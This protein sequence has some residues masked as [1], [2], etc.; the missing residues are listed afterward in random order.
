[1]VRNGAKRDDLVNGAVRTCLS[2]FCSVIYGTQCANLAWSCLTVSFVKLL[3]TGEHCPCCSVLTYF[4]AFQQISYVILHG[5]SVTYVY[6][7]QMVRKLQKNYRTPTGFFSW[8]MV[9]P[10]NFFYWFFGSAF[11]FIRKGT[12][13]IL[14]FLMPTRDL[15]YML[16]RTRL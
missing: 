9:L 6:I 13:L 12:N 4:K 2:W 14:L 7:I 3:S 16:L 1:M 8:S 15:T 10:S 11:Y 5:I